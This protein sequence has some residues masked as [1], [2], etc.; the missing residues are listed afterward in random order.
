MAIFF[1]SVLIVLI[2][3]VKLDRFVGLYV[4]I[5]GFSVANSTLVFWLWVRSRGVMQFVNE[6]DAELRYPELQTG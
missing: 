1:V 6:R 2:I 5:F 4:G 3:G